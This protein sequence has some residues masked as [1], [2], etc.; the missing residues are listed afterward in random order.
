MKIFNISL[1]PVGTTVQQKKKIGVIESIKYTGPIV[2][3][4]SGTIT[5]VNPYIRKLGA[6]AFKD[7]PYGTGWLVTIKP[8][9]LET[10]LKN[11]LS[12]QKALEWFTKEAEKSKDDITAGDF[13]AF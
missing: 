12:G 3:P 11:I 7:D 5:A 6:K 2:C 4:I 8:T 10:E 13:K 9:N 1:L